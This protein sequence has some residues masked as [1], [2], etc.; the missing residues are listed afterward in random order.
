MSFR[1]NKGLWLIVAA[2]VISL[3]ALIWL[4]LSGAPRTLVILFPDIGEL[5]HDD[6]VLWHDYVVGRVEKIEPLV[7][8]QIGV[9]IRLNE[10]YAKKIKRGTR[11]TLKRTALFGYVGSNAITVET[12]AEGS[13][14]YLEG[15]KIQGISP[16][17]PTLVEQGKQVT[18]EYW[19]RLKD[20]AAELLDQYNQSPYRK[21]V[22]AA[23]AELK[24]LA[25]A[26]SK[27]AEQGL[28]QFRKDHQ[29]DFDAVMKKLEQARDWIR[30]KGD[31]SGARKIQDEIDRLKK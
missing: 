26:G 5:K 4:L 8:D 15:E 25:E 21:E 10:D 28:E 9:T 17:K 11:F 31:E 16:P 27:Q 18:R 6:P 19:Q 29:K 30:K 23:L 12:P 7:D 1:E 14:P 22:E 3:G 2:I 20:Q 24:T 13:L